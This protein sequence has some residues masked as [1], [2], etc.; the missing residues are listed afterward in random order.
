MDIPDYKCTLRSEENKNDK[1]AHSYLPS[2][3]DSGFDSI[4][5]GSSLFMEKSFSRESFDI[6]SPNS[7]NR[8]PIKQSSSALKYHVSTP[9]NSASIKRHLYSTFNTSSLKRSKSNENNENEPKIANTSIHNRLDHFH[10]SA[11]PLKALHNFDLSPHKNILSSTTNHLQSFINDSALSISKHSTRYDE[12]HFEQP[13]VPERPSK[14]LR[15]FAPSVKHSKRKL[16]IPPVEDKR[17]Q[18]YFDGTRFLNIIGKLA[19]FSVIL[20]DIFKRLSGEDLLN[21]SLVSRN[22]NSIVKSNRN[23][24]AR[25][26]KYLNESRNYK[27]NL[28]E[29]TK[30]VIVHNKRH[31]FS[32]FNNVSTS[33]KNQDS[34][35]PTSSFYENQNVVQ[36]LFANERLV[37][38]PRCSRGS[39]VS[40]SAARLHSTS[41]ISLPSTTSSDLTYL[42]LKADSICGIT[43][44]ENSINKKQPQVSSEDIGVCS[45]VACKYMF[46]PKCLCDY[47]P[48]ERC[49]LS[50]PESPSKLL[51]CHKKM[52]VVNKPSSKINSK[53]QSLRRLCFS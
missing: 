19:Q 36:Q 23:A 13:L 3:V 46:C 25:I 42:N 41:L 6:F 15:Y 47:H 18:I 10:D 22:W 8:T 38:C 50:E 14:S 33:N 21:V 45:S 26:Q 44:D 35:S 43:A 31:P 34:S 53:R 48:G 11:C 12:D 29:S 4:Y 7:S 20:D 27:E 16:D 32:Q 39:I 24:N 37:K 9:K 30:P 28:K 49:K 51:V 52:K 17:T 1:L 5:N 40:N 2:V